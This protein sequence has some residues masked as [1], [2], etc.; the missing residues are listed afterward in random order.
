MRKSLLFYLVF[1]STLGFSQ[2]P[3]KFSYQIV[4][5]NSSNQLLAS[6][7]VGIKISLLQGS[8]TG[9]EVYSERHTPSTNA[10]GLS[11]LS[12]RTG[13]VLSGNFKNINL[14]SGSFAE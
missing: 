3:Q 13:A 11:T 14:G 2:T 6:Q 4:I 5:R 12:M 10:N 1:I 9:I 7:Q 8:E